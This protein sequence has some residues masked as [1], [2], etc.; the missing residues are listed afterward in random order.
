MIEEVKCSSE[1]VTDMNSKDKDNGPS[2]QEKKPLSFSI[3]SILGDTGDKKSRDAASDDVPRIPR[4]HLSTIHHYAPDVE[5]TN[6]QHF[7]KWYFYYFN[8]KKFELFPK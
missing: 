6:Y 8:V 7:G 1:K 2:V 5:S 3:S 4:M